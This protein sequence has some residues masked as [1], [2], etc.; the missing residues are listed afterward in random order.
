[1]D[2]LVP[3]R[4]SVSGG[5][6]CENRIIV[7]DH[8][9][10]SGVCTLVFSSRRRVKI[11]SLNCCL[12]FSFFL[13]F[14]SR[15]S[16]VLVYSCILIDNEINAQHTTIATVCFVSRRAHILSSLPPIRRQALHHLFPKLPR[17]NLRTVQS[18]VSK[19]AKKHGLVYH[20][21]PFLDANIRTYKAM[22]ET[23][24]QVSRDHG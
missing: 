24:K 9:E 14:I 12:F 11:Y 19:L 5:G 6:G 22:R 4:S 8:Q 2:G 18:R 3:R 20:L 10:R 17:Y 13:V 15:V 16:C 7:V 23:A 1:M 21:Y